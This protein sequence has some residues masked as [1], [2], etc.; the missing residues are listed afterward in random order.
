MY[1]VRN[2]GATLE[3][4]VMEHLQ[5]FHQANARRGVQIKELE[6]QGL[7]DLDVLAFAD[8]GLVITVECKSSTSGIT[9]QHITRYLR[10][11]AFFP[12]DIALLLIDTSD[13]QQLKARLTQ[14]N[15]CLGEDLQHWDDP[16]CYTEAGSQVYHI[17]RNIYLGNTGGGIGATLKAMIQGATSRMHP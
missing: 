5:Y 11:A 10:R 14:I 13:E 8:G 16:V 9:D 7:G 4:A 15:L 12:A 6:E 17:Q 1:R 3:W 2:L